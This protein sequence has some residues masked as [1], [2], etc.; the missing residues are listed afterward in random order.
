MK[1]QFS[2]NSNT[3]QLWIRA[4]TESALTDQ[5]VH[6]LADVVEKATTKKPV[7]QNQLI[8]FCKRRRNEGYTADQIRE[9][10]VLLGR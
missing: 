10:F 3:N 5:D 2:K 6:V 9:H 4:I 7:S 8:E 1:N